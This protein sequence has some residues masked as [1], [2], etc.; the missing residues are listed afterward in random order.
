MKIIYVNKIMQRD[1]CALPGHSYKVQLVLLAFLL[2]IAS[3]IVIFVRTNLH[4]L[5]NLIRVCIRQFK[6]TIATFC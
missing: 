4:G 5:F 2:A 6:E 3:M 1:K